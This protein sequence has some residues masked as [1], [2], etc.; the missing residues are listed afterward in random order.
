MVDL[1]V[2]PNTGDLDFTNKTV[3]L[4][5]NN[6]E[7]TRQRIEISLRTYRGEWFYNINEGIPY[8]EN[9]NNPIQLIG[10][11][12]KQDFDSYIKSSIN[13]KPFVRNITDYSSVFDKY[14]G[15]L[16]IFVKIDAGEDQ[17]TE[18]PITISL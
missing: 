7:L 17:A 9:A 15:N 18:I 5:Q 6:A 14:Q 8:L 16:S 12:D 1:Y 2:N 11:G 3:R 10:K 4:T 13:E